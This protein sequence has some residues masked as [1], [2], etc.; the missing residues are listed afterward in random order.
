MEI[1]QPNLDFVTE[2][3]NNPERCEQMRDVFIGFHQS[4]TIASTVNSLLL[5]QTGHRK[6]VCVL[7]KRP[8]QAAPHLC[9][10]S[11]FSVV[12]Y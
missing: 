7:A 6:A 10:V 11:F 4:A 8:C 3:W 12:T 9:T 2:L 1:V 5:C